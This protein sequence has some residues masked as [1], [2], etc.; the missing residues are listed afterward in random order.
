MFVID[1]GD[2]GPSQL[3]A[4][5][6]SHNITRGS[7]QNVTISSTYR[8]DLVPGITKSLLY[9]YY[10]GKGDLVPPGRGKI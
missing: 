8:E 7:V 6:F 3:F 1:R 9:N 10:S 4:N 5:N 2:L